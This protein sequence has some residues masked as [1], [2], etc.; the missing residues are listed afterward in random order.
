MRPFIVMPSTAFSNT[1]HTESVL[2]RELGK[3]NGARS[4]SGGA[5]T[6][7]EARLCRS[8]SPMRWKEQ[9]LSIPVHP[10][11]SLDDVLM[12]AEEAVALCR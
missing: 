10:L 1:A 9:W 6:R 11:L 5:I 3:V 8:K 4:H 7:N 12:V 2:A